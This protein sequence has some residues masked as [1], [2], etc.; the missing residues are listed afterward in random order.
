MPILTHLQALASLSK[1]R[2]ELLQGQLRHS[3]SS[4][5]TAI[6]A[7]NGNNADYLTGLLFK[8]IASRRVLAES[9]PL[10]LAAR[11]DEFAALGDVLVCE[12]A[13]AWA[14]AG[15]VIGD[16]RIPA[17][18]RQ[19]LQLDATAEGPWKFGRHLDREVNRHTR[20]HNFRVVMSQDAADKRRFFNEFYVPYI[21]ARHTDSAVTVTQPIFDSIA[22]SATLAKLYAGNEWTAGMLLHFGASELKFGWFGSRENP[23]RSGASDVLDSLC[24]AAAAERGIRRINFGNARPSLNDGVVRYKRKF[25]VQSLPPRYPQTIIEWRLK[26][27]RPELREWMNTQEFLCVTSTGLAAVEYPDSPASRVAYKPVLTAQRPECS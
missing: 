12:R 14:A 1:V 2:I 19:E 10:A 9:S 3:S 24:V 5:L 22:A 23:P 21:Q 26:N 18:I 11:L 27:A 8:T 25:G 13:P 20:R 6:Y 4:A 15:A 16:F 7:G 17:W